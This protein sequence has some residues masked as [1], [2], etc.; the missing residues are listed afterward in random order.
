MKIYFDG[1]GETVELHIALPWPVSLLFLF[2]VGLVLDTTP[3]FHLEKGQRCKWTATNVLVQRNEWR[4]TSQSE[5]Q[6]SADDDHD[7]HNVGTDAHSG[8][9]ILS[10]DV[11][12]YGRIVVSGTILPAGIGYGSVDAALASRH[13][14]SGG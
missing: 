8:Q 11:G 3:A 13:Q 4:L 6:H 1:T 9:R 2:L 5:N 12:H 10:D 7:E 14:R